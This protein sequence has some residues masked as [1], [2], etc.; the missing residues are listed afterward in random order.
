MI[1]WL[2]FR[3]DMPP[4]GLPDGPESRACAQRALEKLMPVLLGLTAPV[5]VT[6][7]VLSEEIIVI[8]LG[9]AWRAAAPVATILA[10]ALFPMIPSAVS[11]PL[12][13]LTGKTRFLPRVSLF[14]ACVT[15]V[16]IL[17]TVGFGM[18][19]VAWAHLAIG[20]VAFGTT[21]WLHV[22]ILGL[23][24]WRIAERCAFLVPIL[25]GLVGVALL[26]RDRAL[27]QGAG[28]IETV[29]I[30]LAPSALLYLAAV[31]LVR[32]DSLIELRRGFGAAA[33]RA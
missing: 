18:I 2:L 32:R 24:W 23:D 20:L 29:A 3:R 28:P 1:S 16:L 21:L 8:L 12:L 33:D 14:N 22:R 6:V 9:E 7:A 27:A 31:A 19:A 25:I 4:D 10:L 11:E 15:L 13:A 5:Y 17:V 30:V 26:L